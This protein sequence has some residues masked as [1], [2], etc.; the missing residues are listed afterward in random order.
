MFAKAVCVARPKGM[1]KQCLREPGATPNLSLPWLP[2]YGFRRWVIDMSL[3]EV[4]ASQGSL[5]W[6][7][8]ASEPAQRTA[9]GQQPPGRDAYSHSVSRPSQWM[10]LC[11][12]QW[13]AINE[14]SGNS[15]AKFRAGRPGLVRAACSRAVSC[16]WDDQAWSELLRACSRASPA[17]LPG[18]GYR[19]QEK[20]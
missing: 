19:F 18:E 2:E 20:T 10:I 6:Y 15:T 16:V 1:C 9:R 11:L 7:P 5:R 17:R 8:K 3:N 13:S 14:C 4:R 12:A